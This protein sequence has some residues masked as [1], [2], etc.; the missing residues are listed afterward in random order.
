MFR[1]EDLFEDAAFSRITSMK[2]SNVLVQNI[3]I[4]EFQIRV[5]KK[6]YFF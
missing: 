6:K 4:G 2:E 5:N 1:Y 3:K